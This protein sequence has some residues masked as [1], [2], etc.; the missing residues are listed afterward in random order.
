MLFN[1]ILGLDSLS[2]DVFTCSVGDKAYN[3]TVYAVGL[4]CWI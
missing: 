2:A 4:D 3:S 1:L